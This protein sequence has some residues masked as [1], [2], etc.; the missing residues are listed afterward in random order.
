MESTMSIAPKHQQTRCMKCNTNFPDP[1][2]LYRHQ[3][4]E[5]HFLC[6]TCKAAFHTEEGL[7]FHKSEIHPADQDITCPGCEMKFLRAGAWMRHIERRQCPRIFPENIWDRRE[8]Q[9][10]FKMALDNLGKPMQQLDL[11]G[12]S[13][14]A[15][16]QGSEWE[17]PSAKWGGSSAAENINYKAPGFDGHRPHHDPDANRL[18]VNLEAF[19]RTAIQEYRHGNSKQPDLLTGEHANDIEQ[20]P[21]NAWAR[22]EKLFPEKY[23][24]VPPPLEYTTNVSLP[25]PSDRPSGKRIIDPYHPDFNVGLFEDPIL[26][27]F[28]CP[29]KNCNHKAKTGRL[30]I[31]H[32]KGEKHSGVDILCP[33]CKHSYT[34]VSGWVQHAETVFLS[35]CP[36]RKIDAFRVI[37]HQITGGSLD[38]DPDNPLEN[39]T[40]RFCIDEDFI[41]A[42]RNPTSGPVTGLEE[43]DKQKAEEEIEEKKAY[44]KRHEPDWNE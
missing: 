32:L 42:L 38:I 20:K 19:P 22:N 31:L 6:D 27:V 23:H 16:S 40:T 26:E 7:W 13:H 4:Q 5:G 3:E 28:K 34:S 37:L 33:A 12:H 9:I 29:H 8:K 15:E 14:N 36:I 10:Q 18:Y 25:S 30:L 21:Q 2:K 35:K 1:R 24:F 41:K 44:W 11:G 43:K 39:D 17:N